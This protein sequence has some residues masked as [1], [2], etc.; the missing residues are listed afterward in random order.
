MLLIICRS[1]YARNNSKYRAQPIIRAVDCIRHPPAASPMPAFALQDFVEC[2][3]RA[4]R[5]RHCAKGS[6]MR[7]FL[8]CAAPQKLLHTLLAG[9]GTLSLVT[10]FG[11]LPF[12]RFLHP[13]NIDF[14]PSNLVPP[15]AA[16]PVVVTRQ[17]RSRFLD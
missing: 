8:D 16:A 11:F 13:T 7:F 6:R 4:N 2:G 17:T 12:F 1:G 3:T 15:T 10:K 9:R 14:A 5:R